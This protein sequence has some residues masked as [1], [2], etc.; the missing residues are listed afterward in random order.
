MFDV[1]ENPFQAAAGVIGA[2]PWIRVPALISN[3]AAHR[4]IG[5]TRE[6]SR[7]RVTVLANRR[8]DASSSLSSYIN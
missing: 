8:A 4:R 7:W 3:L 6:C 5:D 2:G 1:E